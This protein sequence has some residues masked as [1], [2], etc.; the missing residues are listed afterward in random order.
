[1]LL[2]GDALNAS[3]A[4]EIGLINEVVM[5]KDL[6]KK[7]LKIANKIASKSFQSI[8]IGKEAFYN[9]LEM[10]IA[11]A[12]EYTSKVVAVNRQA[13]EAKEGV[14]AFIEKRKPVWEK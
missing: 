8:K 5:K 10:P 6:E 13:S 2:T 9:Q 14:N 12:Y 1:M 3:K 4:K 7:V 11:E